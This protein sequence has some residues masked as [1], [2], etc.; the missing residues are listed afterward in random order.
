MGFLKQL[1]ALLG[2]SLLGIPQRLELV[3]TT[4]IGVTCAVGVL[5]SMLA[6]GVGARREALGNVRPDRVILLSQGALGPAGSSIPQNMA[7]LIPD[8]PGIRRDARGN[9]IAVPK[10]LMFVRAREKITGEP[11]GF[12]VVGAGAELA[13]YTPELHLTAGRMFRPGLRELIANNYCAHALE[14]FNVGDTRVIQ[15]RDWRVVGNF[16]LGRANGFC[17]AYADVA[18]VLSAFGRSDFNE[19]NVMLQ[20]PSAYD[21][22]ASAIKANPQLQIRAETEAD[23]AKANFATVNGI[24]NFVSY[25][26]GTIMAVA[27]TIGAANSLDAAVDARR[28]ELATLRAV[29]FGG[30]PVVAAT[31]LEA[32]LVALP[33]ALLGAALAWILFDGRAAN[34]FGFQFHLAVTPALALLGIAWSLGMGLIAGLVPALRSA[35]VPVSAALRAT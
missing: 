6:M 1:K 3:C 35:R 32:M 11:V 27:A 23:L 29:G 33:G 4:V 22:L 19:V 12:S 13:P 24:L 28:R 14:N 18:T 34:P 15:G 8:L 7:A 9:P 31:L 20:S 10:A 21:E 16:D 17:V 26:V 5:V 2:M 30:M 25:F